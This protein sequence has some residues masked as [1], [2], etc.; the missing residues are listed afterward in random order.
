M[1]DFCEHIDES[2]VSITEFIDC[3]NNCLRKTLYV[4]GGGIW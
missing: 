1:T 2:L 3:L 4:G